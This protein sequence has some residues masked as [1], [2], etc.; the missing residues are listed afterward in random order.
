MA[1]SNY[2]W[3]REQSIIELVEAL[4]IEVNQNPDT[5]TVNPENYDSWGTIAVNAEVLVNKI[6]K[7]LLK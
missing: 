4:E 2:L 3:P 1:T 5:K 7:H 6:K